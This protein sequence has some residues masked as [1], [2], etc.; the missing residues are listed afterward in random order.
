MNMS[1]GKVLV[2]LLATVMMAF[3]AV[4]LVSGIPTAGDEVTRDTLD[5]SVLNGLKFNY[6]PYSNVYQ[7]DIF[8]NDWNNPNDGGAWAGEMNVTVTALGPVPDDDPTRLGEEYTTFCLDFYAPIQGGDVLEVDSD[9]DNIL[10]PS[11]AMIVNYILATFVPENDLQGAAIQ[12]AI[13]HYTTE[14]YGTFATVVAA[15]PPAGARDFGDIQYQFMTDPDP[16][17]PV[18]D[19][20]DAKINTVS[21]PAFAADPSVLRDAAF[22]IIDA[23][24]A[25][26]PDLSYPYSISIAPDTQT[27]GVG[28]WAMWTIT[29]LDQHG[30][31]FEGA[32][33]CFKWMFDSEG[34]WSEDTAI[35]DVNGEVSL[36]TSSDIEDTL[37]FIACIRGGEAVWLFDPSEPMVIQSLVVPSC[38][39][40]ETTVVWEQR[41]YYPDGHTPGFWKNNA[42]KWLEFNSGESK[43]YVG[44]Q[45]YY[46]DY[47]DYL[48]AID[49]Q[50]TNH[51][52]LADKTNL[53][54]LMDFDDSAVNDLAQAYGILSYG[55]PDPML[56]AQKHMLSALLT[57]FWYGDQMEDGTAWYLAGCVEIC[58]ED[59][60]IADAIHQMLLA[61]DSGDF[62]LAHEIAGALNEQGDS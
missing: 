18:N 38:P 15:L 7:W 29:V 44:Y 34:T 14:E 8:P 13:W 35:T 61:Y 46:M 5:P 50:I 37:T 62:E 49:D 16:V 36:M 30:E 39:C 22:D 25:A 55:G 43:K 11:E 59:V 54:W 28:D 41:C 21:Y 12:C 17:D 42:R 56:K 31:P 32:T 51:C 57:V 33:V 1:K 6:R 58:G 48:E 19:K 3:S 52:N 27:V 10:S 20:Y 4:P 23:V 45:V 53:A 60:N 40:D 24:E 2:A 9:L 47:H 26:K